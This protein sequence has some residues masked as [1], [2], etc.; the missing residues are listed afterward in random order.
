M[1]AT[2]VISG[3]EL[4]PT[5]RFTY[6]PDA[7]TTRLLLP[8]MATMRPNPIRLVALNPPA[9]IASY[10]ITKRGADT[11]YADHFGRHGSHHMHFMLV[12]IRAFIAAIDLAAG[13]DSAARKVAAAHC[14]GI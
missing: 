7:T 5:I 1:R 8:R 6:L 14:T 3:V 9:P 10:Q 4:L 13:F 12:A 2:E 11:Q